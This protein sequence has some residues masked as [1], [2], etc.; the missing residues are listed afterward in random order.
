MIFVWA[1]TG[2]AIVGEYGAN[3]AIEFNLIALRVD[4][5]W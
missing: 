2:K 1:V 4:L 5:R 3:V